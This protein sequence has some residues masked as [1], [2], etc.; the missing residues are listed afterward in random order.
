MLTPLLAVAL[1]GQAASSVPPE[2]SCEYA[3]H[4][5]GRIY[6]DGFM[7]FFDWD[8][9]AIRPAAAAIL[10]NATRSFGPLWARCAV[11]IVAHADRSGSA[12]YNL[13]L[14]QRRAAAIL[15]YLR[16]R[17]IAGEARLEGRGETRPL[18]ETADGVREPQNRGAWILV[19]GPIRR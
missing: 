3:D 17:G 8:S 5:A 10:D 18:V 15:A 12:A 1:A 9:S 13:A 7:I 11:E 2:P 16:R 19:G 6:H 14:S 4:P